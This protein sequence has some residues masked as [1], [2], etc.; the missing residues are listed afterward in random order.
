MKS[1]PIE[2][3]ALLSDGRRA[4]LVARDGSIDWL[5]LPRFDSPACF[6]ALLGAEKNGYWKIA[7]KGEFGSKRR[8]AGKTLVLETEFATESGRARLTDAL[9]VGEENPLLVRKLEGL[10]GSVEFRQTVSLRF[11]YGSVVPWVRKTP[12]GFRAIAG[13]D[14]VDLE[15]PPGFAIDSDFR[16]DG[17]FRVEAGSTAWFSMSWS[18][19]FGREYARLENP[20]GKIE[21][22]CRHWESYSD[23][24]VYRGKY[25]DAV[26]RSVLTLKA[27]IYDP[28]GGIVAA[29]T[30]SLP[31]TLGGERNWDYRYC[32]VR[33]ST[34]SLYALLT[35]GHRKEAERWR[36]WLSRAVAG[37]PSQVNIM[38]GLAGERR[39]TEL[40]LS[41]LD[42][43]EGSKPVRTGNAAYRQLQ[44]DVFGEAIETLYLALKSG[45][46]VDENSWR[47]QKAF[48]R[49][50]EENWDQPDEGIWEVRGP[51]QNYTHSKVMAWV[52]VDR[53][54]RSAKLGRL[55]APVE[56]WKAL[57][58]RIHADVCRKGFDPERNSFTQYYGS[59]NVDASLLL[60]VN[61]GFLPPHDPRIDGT[62][63]AIEKDLFRDGFVLRYR[64][65]E[66]KDV[67]HGKEGAFLACSFWLV[68]CWI[69]MGR[70]KEAEALFDRLLSLANDVG[71]LSEEYDPKRKR[72]VGNFPQALS[73]IALV[74]SAFNLSHHHGPAKDRSE[75]EAEGS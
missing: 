72:L 45:L 27:L 17:D 46:P 73:H 38:Y 18:P 26:T 53:A 20:A 49:F 52:A 14:Q 1:K 65:E 16:I 75:K 25:A 6:A 24:C 74:N 58:E 70:L 34:F 15:F 44:L 54:I 22:T 64:T 10:S 36:E 62:V 50:L 29:P 39:L 8:Y 68:D 9:I 63:A 56:R 23:Q 67:L 69:L 35:A 13:P 31:E 59:S 42:G 57:R 51:R 55:E 12:Y 48:I 60:M 43:Y 61:V 33:D 40:E 5:C 47:V 37:T 11:D 2:D 66:V 19:H 28:T 3:Y 21:A 4:A 41:W 30:T 7:P 32:W 71:L